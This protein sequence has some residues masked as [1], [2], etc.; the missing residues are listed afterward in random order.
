MNSQ[1][2]VDILNNL[3]KTIDVDKEK[4]LDID[5][6]IS[7]HCVHLEHYCE[8]YDDGHRW[9]TNY[10]CIICNKNIYINSNNKLETLVLENTWTM[11]KNIYNDRLLITESIK[12]NEEIIKNIKFLISFGSN[13]VCTHKTMNQYIDLK[14]DIR[15]KCSECDYDSKIFLI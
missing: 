2:L 15:Y 9:G 5:N 8:D 14:Y 7:K 6:I 13:N 4:I 11:I 10:Y 12:K 3:Q 1:N